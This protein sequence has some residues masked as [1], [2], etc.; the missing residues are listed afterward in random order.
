M[1]RGDSGKKVSRASR[2]GGKVRSAQ[3]RS[4]LFPGFIVGVVVVGVL[5]VV[6]SLDEN[7]ASTE[8]PVFGDHWHAA[9]GVYVCDEFLAPLPTDAGGDLHT[10][11]DGLIHIHPASN[12][13]TGTKATLGL[14]ADTAGMGVDDESIDMPGDEFD[15]NESDDDCAGEDAEIQIAVWAPTAF[16]QAGQAT[17]WDD[18]P[19]IITEDV[20]D[21]RPQ[22]NDLVTM[23]FVPADAEI[24]QPP[25]I[26]ALAAPE[27]EEPVTPSVTA[28]LPTTP[29]EETTDTT[30]AGEETT[31]TTTA[32]DET[33]DTTTAG[34]ETDTTD[35]TAAND[36]GG[37]G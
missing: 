15:V 2:A 17:A 1:A 26:G 36:T 11:G 37:S 8:P 28:P 31:D 22:D 33:A 20:E 27:D 21:V 19:T 35:T 18:D 13:A 5:L 29:G 4:L 16:N 25:S 30:T 9:Y 32:G 3:Q 10:H 24:P 14:W 6:L 23:A 34:D 12:A 7:V